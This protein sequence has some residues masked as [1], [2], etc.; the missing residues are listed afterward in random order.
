MDI[1][2]EPGKYTV[3]VSGGVDSVV[4]LDL[5]SHLPEVTLVVAH[6]DHGIRHDSVEDRKLVE[7]LAS[8]HGLA[9]Y[10]EEGKL[11]SKT[12]EA[13]ARLKRYEFLQRIKNQTKS[14]AIVTAHH[15]DDLIETAILNLVRG[16][17]RRGLSSLKSTT[18]IRRPLLGQTKA[19]ITKYAKQHKLVWRE[20][21][22]NQED[23]YLR[24]YIRHKVIPKLSQKERQQLLENL[25]E[26]ANRNREIDKLLNQMLADHVHAGKLNRS[27]FINLPHDL[28][29]EVLLAWLKCSGVENI[30]RGQIERT[31]VL[32]KTLSHGKLIDVDA[33]YQLKI[34]AQAL[35]L[36]ARER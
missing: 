10:Y 3:A 12:S 1:K 21:S 9:F 13:S 24:N 35:A 6:F 29:R 33:A 14:D 16:T 25:S 7:S 31:T 22:T 19:V 17:G 4:L 23:K 2:L 15:Q 30:N 26:A 11:G 32:I 34:E 28:A 18:E 5:L 27:W 20:D 36:L 8:Q